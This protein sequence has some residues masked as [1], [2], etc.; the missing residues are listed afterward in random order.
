MYNTKNILWEIFFWY[1]IAYNLV[2]YQNKTN[3]YEFAVI[4][5]LFS[6]SLI[7]IERYIYNTEIKW[8]LCTEIVAL[9]I[10]SIFIYEGYIN[11]TYLLQLIGIIMICG[12]IRKICYINSPYYI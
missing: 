2:K 4:L 5:L 7:V 8:P 11:K 1:F 6:H 12:H 3:I 9:C 10:A